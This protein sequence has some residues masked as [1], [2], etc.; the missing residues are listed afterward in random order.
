LP[1]SSATP[2]TTWLN[3]GLYYLRCDVRAD[4]DA[5]SNWTFM[6]PFFSNA[7]IG[8]AR[9]NVLDGQ[10]V[11]WEHPW[12]K[13]DIALRPWIDNVGLSDGVDALRGLWDKERHVMAS[14]RTW[15]GR[16]MQI[17]PVVR[18]L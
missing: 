8:Y 14:L 17:K 9:L 7:A 5:D 4:N 6:D 3:G 16:V 2:T 13:E 15:D 1:P 11:M 18:N 10:K 12:T